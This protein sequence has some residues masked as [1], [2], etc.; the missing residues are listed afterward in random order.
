VVALLLRVLDEIALFELVG[1]V[2]VEGLTFT[3][4]LLLASAQEKVRLAE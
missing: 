2:G 4:Q 1:D 3:E